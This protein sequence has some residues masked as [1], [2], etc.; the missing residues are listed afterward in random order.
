MAHPWDF[1]NHILPKDGELVPSFLKLS[2][3]HGYAV[4]LWEKTITGAFHQKFAADDIFS[5]LVCT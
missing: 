4:S 2:N 1:R 5:N 3:S